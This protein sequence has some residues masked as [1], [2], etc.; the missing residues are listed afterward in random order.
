PNR[1]YPP[2]ALHSFLGECDFVILTIPLTGDT[3]HMIN[4][5]ALKAMKP[6]AVLVNIARGDIIDEAAL[7][8]ALR[9]EKIRGAAL[10]VFAEEPLPNESPLWG[11]PNVI[12]SP[13]ISG[14]SHL[15]Y[16]RAASLFTENLRRF[17][18]GE[19]LLNQVERN[20]GY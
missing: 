20:R 8:E 4:A 17:I 16:E 19:P 2:E 1:L 18:S 3:Q 9:A 5:A 6:N 13:H 12:I 10:D 11:L 7:I 14:T 15:Y